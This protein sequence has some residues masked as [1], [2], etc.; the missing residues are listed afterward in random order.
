MVPPEFDSLAASQGI[1]ASKA[2]L[3]QPTVLHNTTSPYYQIYPLDLHGISK[4]LVQ[5]IEC[6]PN[7][8]NG[9][10]K[11]SICF[12]YPNP[13]KDTLHESQC[14]SGGS[15]YLYLKSHEGGPLM[16]GSID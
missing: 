14:P 10:C 3:P 7:G 12:L 2:P 6:L 8:A 5:V 1:S 4:S 15:A 11:D 16:G 9:Y 13:L